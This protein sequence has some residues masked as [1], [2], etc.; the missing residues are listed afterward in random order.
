MINIGNSGRSCD[1]L[2]VSNIDRC[3]ISVSEWVSGCL[4]RYDHG[5]A[6]ALELVDC[7]GH[8]FCIG[9]RHFSIAA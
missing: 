2:R 3:W 7:V 6:Q 9:V 4:G 1:G 5:R 8:V